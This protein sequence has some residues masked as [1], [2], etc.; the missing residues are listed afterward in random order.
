MLEF[1]GFWGLEVIPII[2][3][4]YLGQIRSG[5]TQGM[6]SRG[7]AGIGSRAPWFNTRTKKPIPSCKYHSTDVDDE[8]I[9]IKILLLHKIQKASWKKRSRLE[10]WT[11]RSWTILI[12]SS[13][14][15]YWVLQSKHYL[16]Y[17]QLHPARIDVGLIW[18]NFEA[19]DAFSSYALT[20]LTQHE[21]S[22]AFRCHFFKNNF[23]IFTNKWTRK[24]K[25]NEQT[26]KIGADKPFRMSTT[27]W[28]SLKT[29]KPDPRTVFSLVLFSTKKIP[30]KEAILN[31]G[32]LL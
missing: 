14:E 25:N 26:N 8:I 6:S 11:F 10:V 16:I 27:C 13:S 24:Y 7:R 5:L 23:Q 20:L 12:F 21:L 28:T 22:L 17:F 31:V 32:E 15:F 30:I 3:K 18:L 2:L 19:W 29:P 4:P 1:E 9:F